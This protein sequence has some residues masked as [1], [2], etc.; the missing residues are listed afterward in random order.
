MQL[1]GKIS[2]GEVESPTKEPFPGQGAAPVADHVDLPKG[3]PMRAKGLLQVIEQ[4][5]EVVAEQAKLLAAAEA[6]L[7]EARRGAVLLLLQAK[8]PFHE[9]F[10]GVPLGA[11]GAL[12]QPQAD[13]HRHGALEGAAAEPLREGEKGPVQRFGPPLTAPPVPRGT[14]N[15]AT[16]ARSLG[17]NHVSFAIVGHALKPG[18]TGGKLVR[19]NVNTQFPSHQTTPQRSLRPKQN[20]G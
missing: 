20:K 10:A 19:S 8:A 2:H 4:L 15:C 16:A 5:L 13:E 3:E 12:G 11:K 18:K 7:L 6:K 1:H 9:F 17:T 14:S